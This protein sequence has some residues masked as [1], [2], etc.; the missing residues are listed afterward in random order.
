VRSEWETMAEWACLAW[1]A[2][3]AWAGG[4]ERAAEVWAW[5][6]RG[7]VLSATVTVWVHQAWGSLVVVVGRQMQEVADRSEYLY[8][9]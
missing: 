5:A 1:A 6:E 2:S 8:A 9:T 7:W 3:W 4:L